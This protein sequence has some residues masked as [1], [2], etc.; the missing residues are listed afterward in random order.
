MKFMGNSNSQNPAII[1][2]RREKFNFV[3]QFI[4]DN[5]GENAF[6]KHHWWR[7]H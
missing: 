5:I 6:Y 4:L 1:D 3:M 2:E 7:R